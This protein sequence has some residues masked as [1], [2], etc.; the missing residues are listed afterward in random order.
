[1]GGS[2]EVVTVVL[3]TGSRAWPVQC[4]CLTD[5]TGCHSLTHSQR[6]PITA[7]GGLSQEQAL[8]NGNSV[9]TV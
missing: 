2:C 1:M 3:M 4:Q 6:R 7:D 9:C 5:G 8:T